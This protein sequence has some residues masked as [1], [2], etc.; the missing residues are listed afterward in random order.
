MNVWSLIGHSYLLPL[1]KLGAL[2]AIFWPPALVWALIALG[3]EYVFRNMID[4][5]LMSQSGTPAAANL[6]PEALAKLAEQAQYMAIFY[7]AVCIIIVVYSIM[8][9]SALVRWHRHL[10]KDDGPKSARAWLRRAEWWFLWR[11][12]WLGLVFIVLG[13]LAFLIVFVAALF[14]VGPE[15]GWRDDRSE[16]RRPAAQF[17]GLVRHL[18]I[19]VGNGP[20]RMVLSAHLLVTCRHRRRR[21]RRLSPG[22][23]AAD[24]SVGLFGADTR[25]PGNHRTIPAVRH[26]PC[27]CSSS[28]R[29]RNK[30]RPI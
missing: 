5:N 15:N 23:K 4:L 20:D 24:L 11:W 7:A 19:R 10:I 2:S 25:H 21:G 30:S 8:M 9:A 13:M 29:H 28:R 12:T 1:Q 18:D 26:R 14:Y 3:T 22:G 16:P 27:H 6:T 17:L